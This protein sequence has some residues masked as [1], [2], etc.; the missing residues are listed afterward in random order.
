MKFGKTPARPGSVKLRL[1]DYLNTAALPAVPAVFG[2]QALVDSWGMLGNDRFGDCVFAG[3]GHETM[4]WAAEGGNLVTVTT[5]DALGDYAAVTGFDLAQTDP[6]TG[7][8]PT[9]S[10]TDMEFAARYRRTTGILDANGTRHI[11]AAYAAL[12][13]G[14]DVELATAAYLFGAVGIGIQVP[15]YAMDQFNRGAA[16]DLSNGDGTIQGGHYVPVV[17]RDADGNLLVVTWGKVQAMTPAFYRRFNDEAIAYLS[18][19]ILSSTGTS[20]EGFNLAQLQADLS[21][22]TAAA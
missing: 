13:R 19:E 12:T 1:R 10:G 16:W 17:G 15:A 4:L 5:T 18:P 20:P 7:E 22:V 14:D 21:A 9:D 2:H 11:V 6:I 3:A 8:N